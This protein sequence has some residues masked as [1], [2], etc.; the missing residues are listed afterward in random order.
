[1]PMYKAMAGAVEGY[2]QILWRSAFGKETCLHRSER[3]TAQHKSKHGEVAAVG[4]TL[5][6][7]EGE[8]FL[9]H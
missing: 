1:M 6:Y 7:E 9:P 5:F 2:T 3:V 8:F 4:V